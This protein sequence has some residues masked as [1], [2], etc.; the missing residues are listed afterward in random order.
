MK[1]GLSLSL[2]GGIRALL[3]YLF[4]GLDASDMTITRDS[5]QVVPDKD[6]V[7]I[8]VPA[9]IP[10]IEGGKWETTV[11]GGAVLGDELALFSQYLSK[12]IDDMDPSDS[13]LTNAVASVE[14]GKTY[15][16]YVDIADYSGTQSVGLTNSAIT[17]FPTLVLGDITKFGDGII[18]FEELCDSSETL[19][20][21]T[22]GPDAA[23][24]NEATF[25]NVSVRE[26]IP[27]WINPGTYE[28][29]TVRTKTQGSVTEITDPT[30]KGLLVEGA[31][32]NKVTARKVNPTDTTNVA[33]GGDAAATLTV[34][35]DTASLTAA[36]MLGICTSGMVYKLDNSAGV[37]LAYAL[38]SGQAD[39]LNDHVTRAYFRGT[40]TGGVGLSGL[41]P[42]SFTLAPEY[43]PQLKISTPDVTTR[44]SIIRAEAGAVVYFI[45]P[46]LIEAP[47][48]GSPVMP[49]PDSDTLTS[50]T[51]AATVA[52]H[53]T[54]N[55][56]RPNEWGARLNIIPEGA[57]QTGYALSSYTDADNETSVYV[58][59]TQITF[60]KRIAGVD[61][62]CTISYTHVAG[63]RLLTDV[64]QDAVNGM[65]I[66]YSDDYGA[67]WSAWTEVT[68]A[69]GKADC[70][71]AA[72]YERGGRN[73][74][75][76]L[77]I[78][79][80]KGKFLFNSDPKTKLEALT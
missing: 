73:G 10:A 5:A 54:T 80:S 33:K 7:L 52:S 36:G 70:V 30:F 79:Y 35:D 59:P 64:R 8:P 69:A 57:G 40:G 26:V 76:Q 31:A 68:T 72:T 37:S 12:R 51:R 78:N 42:N 55:V 6:G 1:L 3:Q 27:R 71:I 50:I 16:V 14:A 43:V 63:T 61:T 46:E 45:L 19:L 11:A 47:F 9:G 2:G 21:F 58:E 60:R 77:A 25:T 22:R 65:G 56:L 44:S 66:R 28:Q 74:A 38:L 48:L 53:S 75:D 15:R 24:P 23:G 39:T 67:T 29:Q 20:L 32:T 13:F 18:T 41:A 49:D 62:D 4:N 17:A 34:V